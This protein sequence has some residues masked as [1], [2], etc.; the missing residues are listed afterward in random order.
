MAKSARFTKK[1][2][3]VLLPT[4]GFLGGKFWLVEVYLS[5]VLALLPGTFAPSFRWARSLSSCH[6]NSSFY[7]GLSAAGVEASLVRVRYIPI[8]QGW[9]LR[10]VLRGTFSFVELRYFLLYRVDLY[11]F[12]SFR[13]RL[14][15]VFVGKGHF[16]PGLICHLEDWVPSAVLPFSNCVREPGTSISNG[17]ARGTTF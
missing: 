10:M 1:V 8:Y 15:S 12:L 9:S 17:V 5:R 6:S 13:V 11:D 14:F 2:P 16:Y 7:F 4:A 3:F